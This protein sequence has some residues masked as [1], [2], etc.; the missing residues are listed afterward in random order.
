MYFKKNSTMTAKIAL[1]AVFLLGITAA[2]RPLETSQPGT[3]PHGGRVQ[4]A[5]NFNIETK[6]S[7]PYFYAYLLT[8]Q[9][10]SIANKGVAGEIKFFFTDSSSFD[11]PLK[12]NQQD[13][14]RLESSIADYN[15]YRV[16]FHAFGRNISAKFESENAIVKK[17]N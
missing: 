9:N 4:Q 17:K 3:G 1:Y 5:E 16:T 15:A 12:P 13:G 10:K 11:L 2:F 14:F 8:N 6:Y 7:Y